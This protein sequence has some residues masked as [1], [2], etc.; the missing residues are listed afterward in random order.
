MSG[1]AK[2]Y[3]SCFEKLEVLTKLCSYSNNITIA[4]IEGGNDGNRLLHEVQEKEGDKQPAE[5]YAQE[6]QAGHPGCLSRVRHKSIQNREAL[7]AFGHH[8][9]LPGLHNGSG[10]CRVGVSCTDPWA[11]RLRQRRGLSW[12][13]GVPRGVV[14]KSKQ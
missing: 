2:P 12:W 8:R 10:I 14:P 9:V 7:G 6:S 11:V 13:C 3:H 5:G 4:A 1:A